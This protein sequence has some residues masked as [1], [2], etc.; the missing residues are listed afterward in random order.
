VF[1]EEFKSGSRIPFYKRGEADPQESDEQGA[2][3]VT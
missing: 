1:C 2:R 3:G